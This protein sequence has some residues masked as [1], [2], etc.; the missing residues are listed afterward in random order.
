[1]EYVSQVKGLCGHVSSTK[2]EQHT[3][4]FGELCKIQRQGEST[5]IGAEVQAAQPIVPV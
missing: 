3:G 2:I 4:I 1:M 5:A